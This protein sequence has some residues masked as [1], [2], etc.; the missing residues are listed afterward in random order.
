MP[1]FVRNYPTGLRGCETPAPTL[2][3]GDRHG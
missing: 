1:F 2:A 3:E